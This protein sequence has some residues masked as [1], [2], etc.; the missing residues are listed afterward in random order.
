MFFTG[1]PVSVVALGAAAVL[2]IGR[3][4]PE[5]IYSQID[6]NLLVM[7]TGLFVVVHAFEHHI[8][9][10]WN[11][12]RL[13]RDA[14][15]ADH[16]T[17]RSV[18]G[19]LELGEQRAG[20]SFCSRAR[21]LRSRRPPRAAAGSR[22]RWRR[23][24]RRETSAPIAIGRESHRG[25]EAARRRGDTTSRF[26]GLNCKVGIPVTIVTLVIPARLWLWWHPLSPANS[27]SRWPVPSA[28]SSISPGPMPLRSLRASDRVHESAKR[29]RI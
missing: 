24:I 13:T 12:Q 8:V 5:R 27:G 25:S 28:A 6:W 20:G 10:T 22:S 4:R 2:M 1:V 16:H 21:S 7:F 19:A 3:V 23:R 11:L 29:H 18:S 17:H 9:S 15:G 14:N 26:L